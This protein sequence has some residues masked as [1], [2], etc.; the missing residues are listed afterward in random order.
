LKQVAVIGEA[1]D[2]SFQKMLKAIRV[3]YHPNVVVAASSLPV[4]E[5]AP[6]LLNERGMLNGK[7]TVYVCEGFVCKQPTTDIETLGELLNT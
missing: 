2:G 7:A 6:A 1:G 5:N 4:N 3:E